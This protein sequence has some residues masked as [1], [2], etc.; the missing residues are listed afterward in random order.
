MHAQCQHSFLD[1]LNRLAQEKAQSLLI[2]MVLF[3]FDLLL[4]IDD[5]PELKHDFVALDQFADKRLVFVSQGVDDFFLIK[6]TAC[7]IFDQ[8]EVV[9]LF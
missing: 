9:P 8:F 6:A 3:A 2:I 7:L 5:F 1:V 4:Q